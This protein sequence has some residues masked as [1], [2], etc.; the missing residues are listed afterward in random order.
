MVGKIRFSTRYSH[1]TFTDISLHFQNITHFGAQFFK[2]NPVKQPK[3]I[4]NHPFF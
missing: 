4:T 1:K 3:K 2:E